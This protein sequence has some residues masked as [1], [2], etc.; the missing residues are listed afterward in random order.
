[1][2][3][4]SVVPAARFEFWVGGTFLFPVLRS[5]VFFRLCGGAVCLCQFFLLI[6]IILIY[7]G[8]NLWIYDEGLS[9]VAWGAASFPKHVDVVRVAITVI[10]N[11]GLSK[12]SA[13]LFGAG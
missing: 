12:L 2:S 3:I 13:L 10:F 5:G 4:G 9:G 6:S 7:E 1:M 8:I 11:L